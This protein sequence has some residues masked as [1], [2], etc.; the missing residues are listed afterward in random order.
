M[1]IH[2]T[3]KNKNNESTTGCLQT[4]QLMLLFVTEQHFYSFDKIDGKY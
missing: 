2:P 1:S 3:K 4:I